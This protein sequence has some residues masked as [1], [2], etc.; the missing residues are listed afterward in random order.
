MTDLAETII[1]LGEAQQQV[2]ESRQ[3]LRTLKVETIDAEREQTIRVTRFEYLQAAVV[4]QSLIADAERTGLPLAPEVIDDFKQRTEYYT[5]RLRSLERDTARLAE[6]R[7][8]T[9]G[10]TMDIRIDNPAVL[11]HEDI[12]NRVR[13]SGIGQGKF[14]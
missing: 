5:D 8:S 7:R 10:P 12:T 13:S 2:S 11:S 9:D 6:R 1:A 3:V 14:R 4:Y